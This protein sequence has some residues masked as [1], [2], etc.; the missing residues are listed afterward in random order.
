MKCTHCGKPIS[1]TAIRCRYCHYISP[2]ARKKR[3]VV[4]PEWVYILER[5]IMYFFAGGRN[6]S[7]CPWSLADVV[8]IAVLI[9]IFI[10]NDPFHISWHLL[11]FFRN[12]FQIFTR[13]PKLFY[14]LS[15]YMNT[16]ILKVLSLV[17]IIVMIK[18]RN[19]S[20][21][22]TVL[23]PGV[24]GSKWEMWMPL[25]VAVCLF[26]RIINSSNPLMPDLPFNSVFSEARIIGNIVIILA[27]ILVAPVVEEIIFRGFL[28]PALNKY[29]GAY[30]A[31]WIVTVL[32]AMAHY[33]Q[34]KDNPVFMVTLLALGYMITF[35]RAKTGSTFLA[36]IMHTIYNFIVV[37]VGFI[38]HF[39]AGF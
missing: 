20:F 2:H 23:A 28:Y 8:A 25:Y 19:V 16:M 17:F 39:I 12:N 26:F 24:Q 18:A 14:F 29:M 3:M 10:F 4:F 6:S 32:F 22:S 5:H 1:D 21:R 33:P 9:W 27:V 7:K 35:A 37:M 34:A 30:P 36:I 13:E 11:K 38:D 15:L 31:V